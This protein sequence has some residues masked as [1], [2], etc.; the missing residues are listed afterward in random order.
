MTALHY[1]LS[2][3]V[4]VLTVA[5]LHADFGQTAPHSMLS[6]RISPSGRTPGPGDSQGHAGVRW[7]GS[8]AQTTD[9]NAAL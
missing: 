5:H 1:N 8:Q 3:E 4:W 9:F 6:N 2:S 7:P